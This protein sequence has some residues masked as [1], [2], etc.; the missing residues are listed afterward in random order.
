VRRR[1]SLRH[2]SQVQVVDNPV[3]HG[4]IRNKSDDLHVSSALSKNQRI[5][6]EDFSYHLGPTAA[7]VSAVQIAF[8]HLLDDGAEEAVLLKETGTSDGC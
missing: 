1:R 2:K 6:L 4:I 5:D 8:D 7:G 3:H